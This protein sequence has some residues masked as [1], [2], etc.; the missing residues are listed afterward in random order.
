MTRYLYMKT[1]NKYSITVAIEG[2]AVFNYFAVI[3]EM[4]FG[5]KILTIDIASRQLSAPIDSDKV[6]A[7]IVA[8]VIKTLNAADHPDFELYQ[9]LTKWQKTKCVSVYVELLSTEV[10]IF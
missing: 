8:K 4:A 6:E 2:Q 7:L 9:K 1:I 5:K 3:E 10:S